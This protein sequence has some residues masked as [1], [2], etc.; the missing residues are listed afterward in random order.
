MSFPDLN[1]YTA[2]TDILAEDHTDDNNEITNTLTKGIE[3]E[4]V[5]NQGLTLSLVGKAK[6]VILSLLDDALANSL[7]DVGQYRAYAFNR[8]PASSTGT[9]PFW[10][11]CDGT[12]IPLTSTGPFA[13]STSP[14]IDG[15]GAL[16]VGI[17]V[18]TETVNPKNIVDGNS[19]ATFTFQT[20]DT[21]PNQKTVAQ[22]SH[23][24]G[25][26]G[27]AFANVGAK[28]YIKIK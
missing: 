18:T 11:P 23:T 13:G 22:P 8:S 5:K 14:D 25:I 3:D 12:V 7:S 21:G 19:P 20:D 28:F 2:N 26:T 10:W 6:S 16:L 1:T 4:N 9:D 27:D 15:Q 24:H 17:A